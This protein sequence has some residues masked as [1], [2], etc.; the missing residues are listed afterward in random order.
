ME[1]GKSEKRKNNETR[2]D[3][4]KKRRKE[5]ERSKERRWKTKRRKF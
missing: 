5:N 4:C 2:I 1:E 3:G